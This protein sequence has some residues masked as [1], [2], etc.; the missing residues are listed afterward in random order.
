MQPMPIFIFS[1]TPFGETFGHLEVD[2]VPDKDVEKVAEMVAGQRSWL[3]GP[4]L[5]DPNLTR[6]AHLAIF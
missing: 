4:K 5:F 3:I 2:M 1:S 6:L